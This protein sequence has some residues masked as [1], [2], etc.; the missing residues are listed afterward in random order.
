MKMQDRPQD[1]QDAYRQAVKDAVDRS[2]KEFDRDRPNA[3][4]YDR[5]CEERYQLDMELWGQDFPDNMSNEEV[6]RWFG[7]PQD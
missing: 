4:S 5:E 3:S 1:I 2:M 6:R 7:I